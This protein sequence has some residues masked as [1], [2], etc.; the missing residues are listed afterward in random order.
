MEAIPRLPM[1]KVEMKFIQDAAGIDWIDSSSDESLQ[2]IIKDE[3]N[4][5]S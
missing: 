1:L 2:E 4:K 3:I 5:V